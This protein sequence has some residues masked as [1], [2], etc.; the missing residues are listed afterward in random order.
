MS[1]TLRPYQGEA[2]QAVLDYWAGGGGNPLVD[3][4][5]GTGKSMVIASLTQRL[6]AAY[7]HFRVLMLVHSRELVQQ[8]FGA[9]L[10]AWPSAPIGIYS[11]GLNSRRAN[12]RITYASIQSV[13]KKAKV[14]GQR[15][16]VLV[17]ESHLVPAAG[18][19]M[20][21]KLLEDLQDA[22]TDL[23]VCG[24]TATPYRLDSG[25][26][27]DGKQRIFNDVVYSYGIADGIRDGWLSHLISKASKTE[28]DVSGVSRRGGEFVAG[29]LESAVE[30]V[31]RQAVGE[32]AVL[33]ADRRS[34]LV[35]CAGVK[36]AY[37][38][39][40][41]IRSHGVSCETVTGE[42]PLGERDRI[43]SDFKAGRIRA[44]TN[45]QVLTTGFDAPGVDMIAMLR[46]T[47]STS[48]YVQ[49]VGR[50]TRKSPGKEDCLI[51]DFAGNVRRHGPVDSV[52]VMPKSKKEAV[53][54]VDVESVK[55]TECSK[56]N[57]LVHIREYTCKDCGH[58]WPKP[59]ERPKH[60]ATADASVGILST[61]R[62]KPK[63]V[64][65]VR[66]RPN[67]HSKQG[68]PDSVRV[69][70]YAGLSTFS[71]WVPFESYRLKAGSWWRE[72]GGNYPIPDSTTKALERWDEL[73]MPD[74]ITVASRP[75][76]E[77]FDIVARTFGAEDDDHLFVSQHHAQRQA[78]TR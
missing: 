35:F 42:T 51:L 8:N 75:G 66:W 46:P 70:Y 10:R 3:L 62:V 74:S 59:I 38:T 72:H 50:G 64:P 57:S 71:E 40:D 2:V 14:L 13:F 5:T 31:T 15:H 52:T 67:R 11:A 20:Y 53:G 26:L 28:V 18:D 25:L 36:N 61:E 44:L 41:M 24:F 54:K 49:I 22:Y 19:G 68:K 65:V 27:T 73:R 6:L 12:D 30:R 69:L 39:R 76:T 29:E 21:L 34:W 7:P 4:A 16:L 9:L 37:H 56:C 17:D 55:A 32:M 58:E 45:A 48:L 33:G 77:Y 78:G 23:R 63:P 47:L 1:W 43:L 60:E